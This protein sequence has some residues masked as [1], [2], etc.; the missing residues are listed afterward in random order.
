MQLY[1]MGYTP[2]TSREVHRVAGV[3]DEASRCLTSLEPM[4]MPMAKQAI[5]TKHDYLAIIPIGG[6]SSWGRSPDKETAI[7]NA[8][9]ALR[10]WTCYYKLANTEVTINVVDVQGYGKR[11]WGEYPGGWLYGTNE[12]T[13]EDEPIKRSI[14]HV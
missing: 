13:G 9:T 7:K 1:R 10:D 5:D 12:A 4:E 8:I 6:G 11:H 3:A 14:E 2:L